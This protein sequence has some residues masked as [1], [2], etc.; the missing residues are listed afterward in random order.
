MG[1][2]AANALAQEANPGALPV[3]EEALGLGGAYTGCAL[4]ASAAWYDPG[5]LVFGRPGRVSA[6][7][8]IGLVDRYTLRDTRPDG[9]DLDFGDGLGVPLFVGASLQAGREADGTHRH[10]FAVSTLSPSQDRRRFAIDR[11]VAGGSIETLRIQ[12]NDA[13]RYYGISYA[14]R[15]LR[16]IGLG[17]SI[18]L[19]TRS[20]TH[21]EVEFAAGPTGSSVRQ[22]HTELH[23]EALVFRIGGLFRIE[24]HFSLGLTFQPPAIEVGARA[25][26]AGARV[27]DP[28]GL[29]LTSEDQIGARSVIPWQLR[30]GVA[31]TPLDSLLFTADATLVGPVGSAND[32]VRRFDTAVDGG[33]LGYYVAPQLWS[34]WTMNGALGGRGL[35]EDAVPISLGAFVSVPFG[36]D[37]PDV[38]TSLYQPDRVDLFGASLAVGYTADHFDFSIGVT[39]ILGF[40]RGLRA[41]PVNGLEPAQWTATDLS[42]HAIY[43]F[44]TGAGS[45]LAEVGRRVAEGVLRED[46]VDSGRQRGRHQEPEPSDAPPPPP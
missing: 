1:V 23:A 25:T 11:S 21:E 7:F 36:P 3:G 15:L 39:G 45:A 13:T 35:I 34:D 19:A 33:T 24:D 28:A 9:F 8:S 27:S 4:D 26:V 16:E 18:F 2:P 32:P 12:R 38:P 40:G 30:L 5:G 22:S 14:Y 20:F 41:G 10:A 43:V 44:V 37:V 6:S 29:T 17:A 31:W 42:T 46:E